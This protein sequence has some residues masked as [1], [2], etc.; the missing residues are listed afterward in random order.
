MTSESNSMQFDDLE[1]C[2]CVNLCNL[3][4]RIRERDEGEREKRG[5]R[6]EI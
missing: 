2:V 4:V 6:K 5:R 3:T 1:E